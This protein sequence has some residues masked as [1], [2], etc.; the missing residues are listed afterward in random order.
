M[1]TVCMDFIKGKC[2]RDSCKYFHP[3]S[4]LQGKV[5]AA[6]QQ[7]IS[8]PLVCVVLKLTFFVKHSAALYACLLSHVCVL[9]WITSD[10]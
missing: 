10:G 3:P 1:V 5:K 7:Q 9:N 4:H 2:Q 8:L 6:Q